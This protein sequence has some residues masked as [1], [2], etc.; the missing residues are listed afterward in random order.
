MDRIPFSSLEIAYQKLGC[1]KVELPRGFVAFEARK[2]GKATILGPPPD[3]FISK[4]LAVM[5]AKDK[6][7]QSFAALLDDAL[8]D[9]LG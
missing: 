7:G 6:F 4:E 8:E 5:D 3:G 9:A 1:V 2:I